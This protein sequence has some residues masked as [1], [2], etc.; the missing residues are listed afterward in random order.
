M[1]VVQGKPPPPKEHRTMSRIR[2]YLRNHKKFSGVLAFFL[3]AST[4]AMAAWM[5]NG[6]G[7][8]G[9][10]IGKLDAPTITAA[11]PAPPDL[12]PGGDGPGTFTI[13]NPNT[14]ALRITQASLGDPGDASTSNANCGVQ[15]LTVNTKTG[16]DIA[17][18]K[19]VSTVVIPDLFKL[20]ADAGDACQGVTMSRD[21][22]LKF[23]TPGQ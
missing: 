2:H 9:T 4:S 19:G 13:D 18:P 1:R 14:M 10:K 8:A 22:N 20:E 21:V 5:V 16:L 11:A 7:K 23:S 15:Y 3:I 6:H 17:V 12:Y